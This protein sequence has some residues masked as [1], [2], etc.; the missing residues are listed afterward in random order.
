MIHTLQQTIRIPLLH[1]RSLLPLPLSFALSSLLR[2]LLPLPLSKF[3][4]KR[5]IVEKPHSHIPIS[6][7]LG[8]VHT[9]LL[10]RLA[11]HNNLLYILL[12]QRAGTNPLF[13]GAAREKAVDADLFGLAE[14]MG[15]VFG[16]LVH[17]GI[18]IRVVE[19][20][21]V[22]GCEV[23]TETTRASG[24]EEEEDFGFVLEVGDHIS[25]VLDLGGTVQTQVLVLPVREILFRKVHHARHLEVEQDAVTTCLQL[26]EELVQGGEL[27]RVGDE[28]PH[29]G[30][31]NVR[32]TLA[33]AGYGLEG[34][35][36]EVDGV[37]F[38]GQ[39]VGFFKGRGA[40]ED[41]SDLGVEEKVVLLDYDVRIVADDGDGRGSGAGRS[42]AFHGGVVFVL[43]DGAA[44]VEEGAEN[45][46]GFGG[47]GEVFAVVLGDEEHAGF[48]D[49]VLIV[50]E[51]GVAGV[52]FAVGESGG[53][54]D[55]VLA[56]G[57]GGFIGARVGEAEEAK[58]GT[59][60][61]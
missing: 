30:Y 25:S 57:F 22:C 15:T 38:V 47:G 21:A 42:I 43:E 35:E 26:Y 14:T 58:G 40:R 10:R 3:L 34:G 5:V 11:R 23:E 60:R 13:D 44:D 28:A 37:D 45:A 41:T 56:E 8:K 18:P 51:L 49:E 53:A 36:G 59:A 29:G 32:V 9:S 55:E 7:T 12:L 1:H 19:D 39:E 31:D 20:D 33:Y 54:G 6:S 2:L 24:E 52:F 17:G 46:V 27:A 16:L 50:V 61:P 4:L 48:G